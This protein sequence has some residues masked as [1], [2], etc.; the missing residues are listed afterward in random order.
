MPAGSGC[1]FRIC[2]RF[3]FRPHKEF[4]QIEGV[5][6]R[7]AMGRRNFIVPAGSAARAQKTGKSCQPSALNL[8]NS[9]VEC[10]EQPKLSSCL[11]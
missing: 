11:L 8:A 3:R 7:P 1:P 5:T 10:K 2:L 6:T 9:V 4:V